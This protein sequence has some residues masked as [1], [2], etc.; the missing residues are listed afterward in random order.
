MSLTSFITKEKQSFWSGI[1]SRDT[2]GTSLPCIFGLLQFL[3][4][5]FSLS[6]TSLTF[7]KSTGSSGLTCVFPKCTHWSTNNQELGMWTAFGGRA[8][9]E[10]ITFY[11][12]CEVGSVP[13]WLLSRRGNLDR[14]RDPRDACARG[15]DH[16]R[17]QGVG[18]HLQAGEGGFGRNH[19]LI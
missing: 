17:T 9:H 15:K 11:W 10:V 8:F 2:H 5:C 19:T 4:L 14:K 3:V 1:Q 16:E 13:V 7:L 6:V 18:G 12:G